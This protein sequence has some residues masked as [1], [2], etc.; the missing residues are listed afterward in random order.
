MRIRL[1]TSHHC[2]W[3]GLP[4][5]PSPLHRRPWPLPR[6]ILQR[7]N[8]PAPIR[9]AAEPNAS[10]PA[11]FRSTIHLGRFNIRLN[12]PTGRVATVVTVATADIGSGQ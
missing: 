6:P 11:T 10:R 12:I 3:R 2:W 8:S 1:A 5:P 7:L 4:R 9:A